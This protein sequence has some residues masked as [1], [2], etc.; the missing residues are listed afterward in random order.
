[1]QVP[2]QQNVPKLQTM[3]SK[4]TCLSLSRSCLRNTATDHCSTPEAPWSASSGESEDCL[5]LNVWSPA[6][7]TDLPVFVYIR[8]SLRSNYALYSFNIHSTLSIVF[9]HPSN[10]HGRWR[11]LRQRISRLQPPLSDGKFQVRFC[12][13]SNSIPCMS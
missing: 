12:R 5:F 10:H 8:K 9:S 2:W 11:W 13:R 4:S 6:N 3:L 1:M 7:A